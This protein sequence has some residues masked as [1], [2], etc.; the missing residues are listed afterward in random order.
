MLVHAGLTPAEALAAATAE[1]ARRFGLHDRGRIAPGL[2]ADLLLVNGDPTADV[3]A[4]RDIAAIW[5]GGVRVNRSAVTAASARAKVPAHGHV[6]V[7][8]EAAAKAG[9]R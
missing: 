4:S 6:C 3:R 5:Q 9:S 8:F 1:P 2:R 7:G